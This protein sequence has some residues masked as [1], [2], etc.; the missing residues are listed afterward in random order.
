M[1]KHSG[2]PATKGSERRGKIIKGSWLVM[3]TQWKELKCKRDRENHVE[4]SKLSPIENCSIPWQVYEQ[5]RSKWSRLTLFWASADPFSFWREL[6]GSDS[7]W[8][9]GQIITFFRDPSIWETMFYDWSCIEWHFVRTV[10]Q[11]YCVSELPLATSDQKNRYQASSQK[12]YQKVR[13]PS[14]NSM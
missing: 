2:K 11:L 9:S 14:I 12:C 1:A 10:V 5:L 7:F 8:N 6:R 3:E 13:E 4:H